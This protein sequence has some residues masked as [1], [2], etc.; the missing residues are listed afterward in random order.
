MSLFKLDSEKTM[1][2]LSEESKSSD[3]IYRPSL[4]KA[5][6][7]RDGYKAII[8]FL[9]NVIDEQGNT[10]ESAI[11]RL[12]TYV[13]MED[14]RH[15]SLSGYYDSPKNFD[16]QC[17]LTNT[18]FTL[19]NSGNPV[20]EERAKALNK[21]TRFYSYVYIVEDKNQPELE[22]TIMI[23]QYGWKIKEKIK[24][25]W[26][27]ENPERAKCDVF[28]LANGKD[29][30][31]KVVESAGYPNYDQSIFLQ[32]SPIAIKG[33]KMPTEEVNGVTMIA[34]SVQEK[35]LK[36]ILAKEV[37]ISDF[38]PSPLTDV[39]KG[40]IAKI[41]AVLTG[42]ESASMF[43]SN[44]EQ[45]ADLSADDLFGEDEGSALTD[46]DFDEAEEAEDEAVNE[47]SNDDDPF[48]DMDEVEVSDDEDPFA[49]LD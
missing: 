12:M 2:F 33:K 3:G 46:T 42:D 15:K 47:S 21:V 8:R 34:E 28:D 26:R 20:L 27:G 5:T 17:E 40:K 4:D 43:D 23:Y 9:P 49:G 10:G 22:G 39:E 24:S 7:K 13:K 41:V 6:N 14:P 11:T 44:N 1:G 18:F 48:A 37:N 36:F 19:K 29:F 38:E 25:E 32:R 35:I 31:L 30:E 16:E 45:N